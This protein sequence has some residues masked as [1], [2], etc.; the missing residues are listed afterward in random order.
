L[1]SV[2]NNLDSWEKHLSMTVLAHPNQITWL[3]KE[4]VPLADFLVRS[5]ALVDSTKSPEVRK[6]QEIWDNRGACTVCAANFS[7]QLLEREYIFRDRRQ[8]KDFLENH[9]FLLPLLFEAYGKIRIY[10]EPYPQVFLE[11]VT[12]PEV[13]ED[14]KL[15][16]FI[17]TS[18]EPEEA[19]KKLNRLDCEWW[20]QAMDR[21]RGRLCIHL[22]FV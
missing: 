9:P 15:V 5:V 7:T 4:Q 1:P 21:A 20:L 13:P 10:F 6:I 11:V 8:V 16:A 17:Q 22:E 2:L 3:I 14:I 12:D 19:L 18:I